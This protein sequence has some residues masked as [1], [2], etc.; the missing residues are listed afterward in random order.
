MGSFDFVSKCI[1]SGLTSNVRPAFGDISKAHMGFLNKCPST[2]FAMCM[3]TVR[4]NQ[5]FKF[6][7][8][9]LIFPF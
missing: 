4:D 1:H 8:A 3:L 9:V 5:F 6:K 7:G 2:M